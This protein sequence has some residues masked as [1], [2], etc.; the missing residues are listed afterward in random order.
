MGSEGVDGRRGSSTEEGVEA[1]QKPETE[2]RSTAWVTQDETDTAVI[3]P[4]SFIR[5]K[6]TSC[7]A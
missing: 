7:A 5:E 6:G 2:T 4:T 3:M 1:S